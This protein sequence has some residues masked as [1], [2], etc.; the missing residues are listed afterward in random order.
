MN[1]WILVLDLDNRTKEL[2]MKQIIKGFLF[3][4]CFMSL[5]LRAEN[6]AEIIAD[7]K[8]HQALDVVVQ[9]TLVG[10]EQDQKAVVEDQAIKTDTQTVDLLEHKR[11]EDADLERLVERLV[12]Q[13]MNQKKNEDGKYV[14]KSSFFLGCLFLAT[15]LVAAGYAAKPYVEKQIARFNSI[16]ERTCALE[17]RAGAWA[18]DLHNRDLVQAD[19]IARMG[20]D[21]QALRLQV[22]QQRLPQAP[23]RTLPIGAGRSAAA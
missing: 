5:A 16:E 17:L 13:L 4:L 3:F 14:T 7:L 19:Q 21:L 1:A 12:D 8:K 22:I 10:L 18:S 2:D 11:R 6:G 9:E 20:A 23:I 15:A